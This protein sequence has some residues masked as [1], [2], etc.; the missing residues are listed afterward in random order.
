MQD[1]N[2]ESSEIDDDGIKHLAGLTELQVLRLPP[3]VTE[4]GVAE[5]REVRKLIRFHAAGVNDGLTPWLASNKHLWN[6]DL[7]NSR[8][9]DKGFAE[10]ES[11]PELAWLDVDGTRI[12]DASLDLAL[13]SFPHL[14]GLRV[15]GTQTTTSGRERFYAQKKFPFGGF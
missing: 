6:L 4:R 12:T 11:L 7:S 1:L 9:T 15:A 10:L 13:K 5:L 8:I 14:N 2:L 3:S